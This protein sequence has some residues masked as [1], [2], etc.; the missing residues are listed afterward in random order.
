M[1][2]M[3]FNELNK[4][5][6][7]AEDSLQDVFRGFDK[8]AEYHT[9]RV[10]DAFREHRVSDA[11][12]A[13]T[14]GYGY[15]DMGRDTLEKI[16]ARV[17]GAEA[18][19]VRSNI[20]NGTHAIAC[21]L[22]GALKSGDTMLSVTGEPYDTLLTTIKGDIHGS[23]KSYGIGYECLR[24]ASDGGPDYEAIRKRCAELKPAMVYIQHSRGYD[25]RR[26]L[27]VDEI[28]KIANIAHAA[29]PETI[30]MVDNC[31]GEFC[32]E[33]HPT[34]VGVDLMAG[35]LI[36]NPGG[37]LAPTGGYIAG[38]ADLVERAAERLT[39][40]GIG[41]E[42][43]STPGGNRLFYQGFFLAPHTVSQALKTAAFCAEM[44]ARLG[45]ESFP[46]PRE[47]RSDIIQTIRLESAENLVRFCQGI[48]SG[49]PVD[50]YVSPQ[51]APMPGYAD[52]VV[53]AAGT[54]IQ[55]ASLELSC[56]GPLRPPYL[57][58][59]QGGLTYASG[60]LGV[61]SALS[62]MLCE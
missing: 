17:F 8:L 62:K 44:L 27:Y 25:E 61:L 1:A 14:T 51:P 20:V 30:V 13:G 26:A 19:L 9:R 56:D 53:M 15:D 49:S 55:G 28:G 48:Q 54:F 46:A 23:L 39:L 16:Y 42:C 6:D 31:Y 45:F 38:R 3:T 7:A 59:M 33:K 40:P 24:L 50:S 4:M 11:C 22:Y 43:G 32:E 10:L 29:C 18:A 36:K 47:K 12:F 34:E 37:G 57:G 41:S 35:S 21:A 2:T 60:K 58:F 5:A 52:E